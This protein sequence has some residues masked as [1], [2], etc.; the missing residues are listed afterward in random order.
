MFKNFQTALFAV[1]VGI[2]IFSLLIFAL[3]ATPRIR[4]TAIDQL[5]SELFKQA[6]LVLEEY[7]TLLMRKASMPEIQAKTLESAKLSKS[8]V[9]VIANDGI[10]LGDSATPLEK[11]KD[12]ENHADRP[13]VLQARREGR[14]KSVRFSSTVA[15]DLIYVALPLKDR[16]QNIMGFLRFSVP[17]TYATDLVMKTNKSMLV[18]L[19]IA[20]IV[21]ISASIIFAR[22]FS[23]PI[24]RLAVIS[25]KIAEGK[26]PLTIMRRS[27]YEVGKLEEAV[28]QMSRRLAEMFQNLSAER[29]QISAILS[30]VTEGVLAVDQNKRIILAN[31]VL[32]RIF[33]VIEP[34]VVGMTV[35]EGIR[36]NEIA[37]LLDESIKTEGEVKKEIYIDTPTEG[38]FM[39]HASPIRDRD[40]SILGAVCVLYNITEIRKLE[41][42]RSE[43]VANVSHELK[44]PLTA[45][46]NYVETLTS[47]GLE[48]EKRNLDFLK[49]IDKHAH[50]LSALIDDI[51][52]I[53]RL[54]TKKDLGPFVKID[55]GKIIKQAQDTLSEKAKRKVI[56]FKLKC[57]IG[58]C[59]ISGIE[60]QVYRSVLNVLDNAVNYTDAGGRVE[61]VCAKRD[62][63]I[64]VSVSDTG[65]GIS[66]EHLPRIFERFY[67]VDTARSRDL[68]GTGLGL[69]IVK[70][71][72]NIHRGSVTVESEE[73]KGSKFT[74]IFPS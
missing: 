19:G 35:R 7:R 48:D 22:S 38:T 57:E 15:E 71:V 36:N 6:S 39:G 8:R 24:S 44:T 20:V 74:L 2:V 54:E 67:R 65:I 3:I 1:F 66:K 69:S 46:H 63:K 18:A 41:R 30:S 23:K 64:E 73:G 16:K 9:T 27:R 43:F 4:A 61:V 37:E 52:E 14:G 70:H 26:F 10:V 40:G 13:E 68:G 12:L 53:S 72:M 56:D 5:S 47:G 59:F 34:E 50:N 11:V 42:H 32:E 29:S 51:L 55:L 25:R 31:P 33:G 45:I 62:N 28:E 49:K 21:A 58:I 60:D 17:T